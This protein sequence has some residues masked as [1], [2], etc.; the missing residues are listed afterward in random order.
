MN[1][2][3]RL[4]STNPAWQLIVF[5]EH[6]FSPRSFPAVAVLN[7]AEIAILGGRSQFNFLGDVLIFDTETLIVRQEVDDGDYLEF[8]AYGL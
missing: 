8:Q 5:P 6:V 3:E 1:S 7:S 2:I 4:L